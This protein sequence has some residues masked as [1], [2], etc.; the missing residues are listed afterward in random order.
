MSDY[1]NRLRQK[2]L[3]VLMNN[4]VKAFAVNA[5]FSVMLEDD[6]NCL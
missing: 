5:F 3:P 2:Y 4:K 1:N 6:Y